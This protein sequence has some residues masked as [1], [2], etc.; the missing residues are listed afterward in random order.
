MCHKRGAPFWWYQ[1]KNRVFLVAGIA[2]EVDSRV[3]LLEHAAPEYCNHQMR[4]LCNAARSRDPA[5]LDG[6]EL[7]GPIF[8]RRHA[9]EADKTG[10]EGLLLYVIWMVVFTFRVRLP[11]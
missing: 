5:R 1:R 7:A 11:Y 9:A 4:R 2:R 3:E 6:L 8:L 10:I